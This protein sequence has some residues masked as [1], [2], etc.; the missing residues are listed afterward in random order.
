[1]AAGVCNLCTTYPVV[2]SKEE[3]CLGSH[4]VVCSDWLH[5]DGT[6]TSPWKH[7]TTSTPKP[8]NYELVSHRSLFIEGDQHVCVHWW[9]ESIVFCSYTW[10][11]APNRYNTIQLVSNKT[12]LIVDCMPCE[13]SDIQPLVQLDGQYKK[14]H[15]PPPPPMCL[16]GGNTHDQISQTFPCPTIIICI[17]Q[18]IKYWRWKWPGSEAMHEVR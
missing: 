4:P 5:M 16:P 7:V 3:P 1:M 17:L 6:H 9:L 10:G 12:V 14:G 13:R 15:H 11:V 8:Q 18:V 2:T